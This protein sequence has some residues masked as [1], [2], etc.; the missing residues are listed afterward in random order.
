MASATLNRI[1]AQPELDR[2][3]AEKNAAARG[4]RDRS[5]SRQSREK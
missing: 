1:G 3:P 5:P 4:L 2:R